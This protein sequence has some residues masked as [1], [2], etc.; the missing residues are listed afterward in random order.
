MSR[1]PFQ[2]APSPMVFPSIA[3]PAPR[4]SVD[5]NHIIKVVSIDPD[6]NR[7]IWRSQKQCQVCSTELGRT[8]ETH[9]KKQYW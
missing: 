4:P 3:K 2:T 6:A 1:N 8:Q 5:P 7:S 9:V